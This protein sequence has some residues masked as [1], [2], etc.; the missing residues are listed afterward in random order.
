MGV[1]ND[2]NDVAVRGPTGE[3]GVHVAGDSG[4]IYRPTGN[5]ATGTWAGTTP[6]SGAAVTA[7]DLH[8]PGSGHA[9]DADGT[10]FAADGGGYDRVGPQHPVDLYGVDSDGPGAVTVAGGDGAVYER[11]GDRWVRHGPGD[12]D[13]HDI[14]ACPCGCTLAVAGGGTVLRRRDDTRHAEATPTGE[15]LTAVR[16]CGGV[17]VAVGAAGTVIER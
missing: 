16:H 13:L 8:T 15:N 10:V 2:L 17:H 12:A 11:D 1:T 3:A 4:A 9:V 6:G 14:E 7:I 5:G